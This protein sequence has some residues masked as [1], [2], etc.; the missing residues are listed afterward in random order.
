MTFDEFEEKAKQLD[1]VHTGGCVQ[2]GN[3]TFYSDGTIH[4]CGEGKTESVQICWGMTPKRMW[5]FLESLQW[6]DD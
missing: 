2:Y 6:S 5:K 1:F 4:F 3:F